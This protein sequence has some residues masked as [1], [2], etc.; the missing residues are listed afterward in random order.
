MNNQIQGFFST[1]G[2][3]LFIALLV[4]GMSNLAS[5]Q[6]MGSSS[7]GSMEIPPF[8]RVPT[9]FRMCP[10]CPWIHTGDYH[11]E[12]DCPDGSQVEVD[13]YDAWCYWGNPLEYVQDLFCETDGGSSSS[14]D[15]WI[16]LPPPLAPSFSSSDSGGY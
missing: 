13:Y 5:A 9:M 10:T 6:S 12:L 1:L 2:T 3:A 7:E 14:E 16:P 4:C 11:Y 8:I 15:E